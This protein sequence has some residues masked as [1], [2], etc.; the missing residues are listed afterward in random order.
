M[1][2]GVS[3]Y[4]RLVLFHTVNTLMFGQIFCPDYDFLDY[5]DK[6]GMYISYHSKDPVMQSQSAILFYRSINQVSY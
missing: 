3:L 6:N 5:H 4:L 1:I 2:Y